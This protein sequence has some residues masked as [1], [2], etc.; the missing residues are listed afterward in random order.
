MYLLI[1]F[2]P[3]LNFLLTGLF[4]RLFGRSFCY[5][6]TIICSLI[7][8]IISIFIF[9]EIFLMQSIVT[10]RFYNWI[11]LDNSCISIGLLFDSLTS[12]MLLIISF[13]SFLVNL[14]SLGYMSHDPHLIRF[15]SYL[16]LFTFFMLILVTS[17]NFLQLFLGWEGVG[18]CSYLLINFWYTRILANKAAL[19]AMIMNRIADVFFI[20]GILLIYVTFNTLDYIVVFQLIPYFSTV[21]VSFLGFN[22]LLIMLYV[23][24]YL[25]VV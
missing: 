4:G 24:F 18:V 8:F 1:L 23:F 9:Y 3:L 22:F 5:I 15:L 2:L 25:L 12:I 20:V 16:S 21:N 11:L 13:I 6:S 19:K 7:A 17:D 14:Y 10:L